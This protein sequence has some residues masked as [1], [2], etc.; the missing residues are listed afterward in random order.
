MQRAPETNTDMFV[1]ISKTLG[2]H[3]WGK[4]LCAIGEQEEKHNVK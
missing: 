4:S 3:L 1:S 2:R